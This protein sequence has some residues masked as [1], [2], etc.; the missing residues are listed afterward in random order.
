M[1]SPKIKRLRSKARLADDAAQ[2]A[3]RVADQSAI[4]AKRKKSEA[5]DLNRIIEK[6][7]KDYIPFLVIIVFIYISLLRIKIIMHFRRRS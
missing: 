7:V 3:R 1:D 2:A 6:L 5:S 4:L